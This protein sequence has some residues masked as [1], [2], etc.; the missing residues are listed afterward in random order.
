MLLKQIDS[1]IIYLC[2]T[3]FDKSLE[4]DQVFRDDD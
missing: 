4:N 1:K 3:W 2:A